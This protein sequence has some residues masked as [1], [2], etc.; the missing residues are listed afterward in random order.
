MSE[1][2]TALPKRELIEE[3]LSHYSG[4]FSES[5]LFYLKNQEM[6]DKLL[7]IV[8]QEKEGSEEEYERC[9][10]DGIFTEEEADKIYNLDERIWDEGYGLLCDLLDDLSNPIWSS[11]KF[12]PCRKSNKSD[13]WYC[14]HRYLKLKKEGKEIE[15]NLVMSLESA[16]ETCKQPYFWSGLYLMNEDADLLKNIKSLYRIKDAGYKD[17]ID[18][19]KD[20]IDSDVELRLA[21]ISVPLEKGVSYKN[22]KDELYGFLDKLQAMADDILNLKN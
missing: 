21:E 18:I 5:T 20:D 22:I 19:W 6:L 13:N 15:L 14:Q 10:Q 16:S 8:E 12:G 17:P 9:I 11:L 7:D 3:F 4:V 2:G 1:K